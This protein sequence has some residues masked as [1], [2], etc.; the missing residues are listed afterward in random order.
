M[1][2]NCI[3][4]RRFFI[5]LI[6]AAGMAVAADSA[7][8][9]APLPA[10]DSKIHASLMDRLMLDG[11]QT[12]AWIFFADKGTQTEAAIAKLADT[13]NPRAIQR[14][15]LR[16]RPAMGGPLFDEHDLP[17]VQTYVDQV[18]EIGVRVHVVSRWLNA[19]SAVGTQAQFEQIAE[20]PFVLKL[21]PVARTRRIEA[22]N[23]RDL[24]PGP[25]D[26]GT[27]R[28]KASINYGLSQEQLEQ[29]NLVALH[30]QGYTGAGVIVGILD[31]GFRRDHVAFNQPGHVVNV[32]AEYDFVDNDPDA[33]NEPGDP[34]DQHHHGTLILGC[35][36]SYMPGS[37]VGGAYNASF[38]LAKTED[39]TGEYQAEEDNYVA[40]LEFIELNGA[41]MSTSSLGYIDW[42]TQS[43]LDGLTAVT[44]IAANLAAANGL[45]MC[46]AAGNE[47]HDSDPNTSSL[48]APADAFSIIT[49]GAV[50]SSGSIA[51]FSSEGPTADGRVKPEV[52]ARGLSTHTVSSSSTTSFTTADGTS[53]STPLVAC[54]LACLIEAN[55]TWTIADMRS[56]LF[57]TAD[58]YE[59]T[60]T[61]DPLYIRGY[62]I[63]DAY[64]AAQDCDGNG[65]PDSLD[66]ANGTHQ[67]CQGNGMPDVCEI[68][69]G[70]AEDCN[71]NGVPDIC[72]IALPE[73]EMINSAP[74]VLGWME[75]SGSG[76]PLGL[77]DDGEAEITMPF[78]NDVFP[79]ANVQVGNNGAMGFGGSLYLSYNNGYIP[80]ENAFD[81]V[82]ALFPFWD[83]L[84]SDTGEVYWQTVGTAPDRILI[85]EWYNRPHFPGNATIDGD[86]ATFQVQVFETPTNDIY[87]Q[88]LYQDT[89][90]GDAGVNDGAS[91]SIGAQQDAENG[92]QW[93]YNFPGAVDPSTVL[94]FRWLREPAS[95]D[96][97]DNGIPD[98]CEQSACL[99]DL[100]GDGVR[101]LTDFSLFAAAYGSVLGDGDYNPDADF[102][103]DGVIDLTD[104]S[105]FA[106]VYGVPCP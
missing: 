41:D 18:T 15:Q 11:G 88:F 106:A 7:W 60:G 71:E 99:G 87:A 35:I 95:P 34:Y 98:E 25:F 23:V 27:P 102:D 61:H 37:L 94:S 93:S 42:Y 40:G 4:V 86:E 79:A 101:D 57:Q 43:Q 21:Q 105:A 104:F 31:T 89:D 44:T 47:Y 84:D 28:G 50:G 22:M 85:V 3:L 100:D 70:L 72:D 48:I 49:C 68:D 16:G 53:L 97:N 91:A 80:N 2:K 76:T 96:N 17:V 73:P 10:P 75:I 58:Y 81:G 59:A 38:V 62:G 8:A 92:Q 13:Y 30:D 20:L 103:S 33:S 39:T 14:R 32:I 78:T 74:A 54:A 6:A 29:I 52:L 36:G 65:V 46:T 55:P 66:I 82:Q 45:H 12:K 24:G 83:D 9:Q 19:V 63:L 67:D 26:V 1:M 51:S 90:F 64:T 69:L 77:G 5:V 56:A